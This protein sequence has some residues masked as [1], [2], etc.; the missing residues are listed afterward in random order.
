MGGVGRPPAGRSPDRS[1][2]EQD[3]EAHSHK[4][5]NGRVVSGRAS[6][7]KLMPNLYA[8]HNDLLW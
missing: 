3:T 4:P 6:D 8:E 5:V 7:V 1:A 2:L